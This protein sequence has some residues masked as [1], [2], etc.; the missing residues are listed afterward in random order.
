MY[1][2][3]SNNNIYTLTDSSSN[4]SV[5]VAPDRGGV[6]IRWQHQGQDFLY[7]DWER[8]ADPALS[9]RGGIPI[10]FP[11]CGNLPNNTYEL[12]GQTYELKQHGFAR[13]LPW[14]VIDRNTDDAASL[15]LRLTSSPETLA[16]YPFEFELTFTYRLQGNTLTLLQRY[17]NGSSRTMPFST[18]FHPY[19]PAS[20][21]TQLQ[22][23]IP[24][25]VAVEKG[26]E[27]MHPFA[28]QFDFEQPEI[29]WAFLSVARSQSTVTDAH[30]K[31]K[32]TLNYD[33]DFSTLVFWTVA[34]KDFYCLEP[35]SAPRNAMNTGDRLLH[36]APGDS[37]ELTFQLIAEVQN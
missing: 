6:I 21:K 17:T 2:I 16:C 32:L 5:E 10:L 27:I 18:G 4:S 33:S 28:N 37:R 31:T 30:H 8:F 11:I 25:S 7:M 35:W 15:T 13:E 22:F 12:E 9:V 36:L 1:S 20:D 23:D 29:D 24:A 26:T 3:E 34:G 14:R 19:F